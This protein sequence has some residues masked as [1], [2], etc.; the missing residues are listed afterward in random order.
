MVA[1]RAA[2]ESWNLMGD[3]LHGSTV[4][5]RQQK[6]MPV[7]R[8]CGERDGPAVRPSLRQTRTKGVPGER[9][10]G[11]HQYHQDLRYACARLFGERSS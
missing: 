7:R 11:H 9:V 4:V 2:M 5:A 1:D 6:G 3:R 10:R 8:D